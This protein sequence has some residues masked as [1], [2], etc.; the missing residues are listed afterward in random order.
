MEIQEAKNQDK[1][2]KK[3]PT[4]P[5]SAVAPVEEPKPL[6]SFED[7]ESDEEV[8]VFVPRGRGNRNSVSTRGPNTSAGRGKSTAT[9]S[10]A[11]AF[12]TPVQSS[13]SKP[14]VP[15]EEIDPDSFDRGG[16]ARGSVPLVN[17]SNATHSS[18]Q[19]HL[20]GSS[21]RGGNHSAGPSR[22]GLNR[23][24]PRGYDRGSTR[25]RGP[26]V[27][28]IAPDLRRFMATIVGF[29]EDFY[30]TTQI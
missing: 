24:T 18:F 15:T 22:G 16:F 10:P 25:G 28:S 7:A 13:K 2:F 9:R 17:T 29:H 21:T 12:S 6:F 14:Q 23:N 26:L 3:H 4:P 27:R 19:G 20:R 1:Y 5:A 8:V 30:I 11:A